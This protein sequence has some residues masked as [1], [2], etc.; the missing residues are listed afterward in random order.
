MRVFTL[1]LLP[2]SRYT[3]SIHLSPVPQAATSES[4]IAPLVEEH[5]DTLL[6]SVSADVQ[7]DQLHSSVPRAERFLG[8]RTFRAQIRIPLNKVG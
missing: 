3:C 8:L 6:F 4:L 7:E 5:S 2:L 1:W